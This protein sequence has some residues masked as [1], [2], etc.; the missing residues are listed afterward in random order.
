MRKMTRKR[1][2][3]INRYKTNTAKGRRKNKLLCDRYPFLIPRSIWNDKPY[4][5]KKYAY[6]IACDFPKGWWKAFGLMLC[7]DLRIELSKYCYLN[8]FMITDIKEKFGELRIYHDGVPEGCKV[9]EIIDN[10]SV[11]SRN[12]CIDCGKPDT[13]MINTGWFLPQCFNCFSKAYYCRNKPLETVKE[14]YAKSICSNAQMPDKRCYVRYSKDYKRNKIEV[15]ISDIAE[16][17]RKE[18]DHAH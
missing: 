2:K 5:D 18:W 3:K 1:K 13:P 11:L 6:T 9:N 8:K 16:K 4:W 14:L 10:Y 15:D 7:E 17:I 12:I